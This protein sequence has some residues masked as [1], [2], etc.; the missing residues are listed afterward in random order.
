MAIDQAREQ[1]NAVIK[2]NRE[3]I[4]VTEDLSALRRLM[5]AGPHFSRLVV[6]YAAASEAKESELTSR[7]SERKRCSWRMLTSSSR[8]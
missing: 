7:Q 3:V 4:D 6:Q 2:G 1:A 8:L 5:V